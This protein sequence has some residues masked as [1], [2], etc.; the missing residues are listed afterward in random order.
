MGL[1]K[2]IISAVTTS[3]QNLS[4]FESSIDDLQSNFKDGCPTKES[5]FKLIDKKN[6]ISNS[7]T[8]FQNQIQTLNSTQNNLE[9]T[10]QLL[11]GLVNTIKL[12][13]LPTSIPP[14]TGIPI[15]VITTLSDKLDFTGDKLKQNKGLTQVI[16]NVIKDINNSIDKINK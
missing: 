8:Q 5:L 16:P 15:S 7:L 11:S 12:L 14:G 1:E 6:K 4:R 13:P 2:I 10:T 3:T 9:K